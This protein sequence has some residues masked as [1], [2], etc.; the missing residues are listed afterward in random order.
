MPVE[1]IGMIGT[2]PQS[3]LTGPIDGP[4]IDLDHLNRFVRVH[5]D[6]EFDRVL[7]GYF[8]G[9]PDGWAVASHAA[10]ITDRLGFLLAHRPGFVSP[11]VA[12]RQAATLDVLS[13]GRFA[14][15]IITGGNDVDQQRDGDYLDKTER[16]ART[17]EFLDIVRQDWASE[18][19][20]DYEGRFYR[21]T[22]AFSAIKSLQPQI[23]IYFGGSSDEAL[24]V[25]AKHADVWATWG[26]PLAEVKS[27]IGDLNRRAESHGRKPNVS[28]S[29]RPILAS[30][31]EKAWERAHQILERVKVGHAGGVW[32]APVPVP[33]NAGSQ[34]LLE[35]A[36]GG[37]VLDDRLYTAIAE[38]TGA[39]GNSTALVG[40]PEQVAETMLQYYD[41]GCS[42]LLIRG[43]DPVND[44]ID[45]GRDLLPII[46]EEVR[47]RD[48]RAQNEA[49]YAQAEAEARAAVTNS[50]TATNPN[51]PKATNQAPT[52][53]AAAR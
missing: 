36:K 6:G 40:T 47:L 2:N 3:E 45:Y 5:E 11:T 23:P 35:A 12:A 51:R 44:A 34:R 22:Q 33:A 43:Y 15:H 25:A 50:N 31:E 28:I 9:A 52:E 19:P 14:I 8:A 7:I 48:L 1:L 37:D 42:T 32:G 39:R 18:R 27:Q 29:F 30:T 24:E 16:Y 49:S 53:S 26:E 38:A 46:R 20:F 10:S 13:G 17:S 41:I 4:Q 21:V